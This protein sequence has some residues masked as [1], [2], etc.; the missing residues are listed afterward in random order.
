[1]TLPA[2]IEAAREFQA[3]RRRERPSGQVRPAGS[4]VRAGARRGSTMLIHTPA[5]SSAAAAIVSR[6][7]TSACQCQRSSPSRRRVDDAVPGQVG[8]QHGPQPPG[9][10]G[11]RRRELA[12]AGLGGVRVGRD[13]ELVGEPAP[14]R[15]DR[16]QAVGVPDGACVLDPERRST[17]RSARRRPASAPPTTG[18]ISAKRDELGVRV[19][20]RRAGGRRPRSPP[21]PSRRASP[22]CAS[23]R[24]RQ[25]SAV[26]ASTSGRELGEG[27]TCAGPWITTSW[28]GIAGNLFGTTR[29]VHPGESAGAPSGRPSASTS[30]GVIASCPSQNGH[31]DASAIR[32]VRPCAPGR[33]ERPGAMTTGTPVS[34]FVRTSIRR[35][36]FRASS[37]REEI[38]RDGQDRGRVVGARDLEQRLQVA[39]LE[40]DR[41]LG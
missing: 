1:M 18:G 11:D 17:G 9:R 6:G 20:E 26:V 8:A 33:R 15:R 16:P 5:P 25:A 38:D 19:V 14:G 32:V 30:G 40:R 3:R 22:R 21:P 41:V 29:T 2:A 34:G 28:P 31:V 10:V 12:P 7:H 4:W 27:T 39:K 24:R 37:A 23:R 35:R 36:P 13:P